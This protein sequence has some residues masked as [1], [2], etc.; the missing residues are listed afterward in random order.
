MI[1]EPAPILRASHPG[2]FRSWLIAI[3]PKTLPAA[4][5]P[6]VVG[7]ALAHRA[8]ALQ[9]LPLLCALAGALLLQLASNLANDVFDFEH[10]KDTGERLGPVRAVHSG[11]LT[12]RQ[13]RAG[14]A[15]VL[16]GCV[17]VGCYL[18]WRAGWPLLVVGIS[19]MIAAVAYTAGPFPLG[20]HGLGDLFVFVFFGPVAV[21]GTEYAVA[22][23][24]TVDACWASVSAGALCANILVVNNLRDLPEDSRTGKRTLVVRYGERFAL[25]QAAALSLVA[26]LGPLYFWFRYGDP[27]P[28]LLT[29]LAAP[30]SVIWWLKL[31]T[32][33]GR[34][35]NQ[36]LAAAARQLLVFSVL[37]AIGLWVRA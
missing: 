24:A 5:A 10:G 12:P 8:E 4:V 13:A 3:R 19:A 26:Q 11:L 31:R 17:L 15:I 30:L 32:M 25:A 28:V 6:V 34:A 9:V 18:V 29:T 1:V 22:G 23:V 35:M 14:L 21:V 7:A 27:W 37:Y 2:W 16:L 20:Y 33:R 36:L